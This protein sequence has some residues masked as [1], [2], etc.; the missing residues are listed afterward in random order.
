MNRRI[1][2]AVRSTNKKEFLEKWSALMPLVKDDSTE[3]DRVENPF[4]RICWFAL[5]DALAIIEQEAD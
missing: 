5:R 1:T 2:K 4:S 3:P